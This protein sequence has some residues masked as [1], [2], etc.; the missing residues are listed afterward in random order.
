MK[1][2]EFVTRFDKIED[3]VY[4]GYVIN[5]SFGGRFYF[6]DIKNFEQESIAFVDE[7]YPSLMEHSDVINFDLDTEVVEALQQYCDSNN[8][9]L[10]ELIQ[11][12]L[13]QYISKEEQNV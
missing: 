2:R 8:I 6:S 4:E 9:E 12:S 3:N 1:Y 10:E 13:K 11:T 5:S 7:Y